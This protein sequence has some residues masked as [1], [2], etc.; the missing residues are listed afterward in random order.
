LTTP[1]VVN[2]ES[3]TISWKSRVGGG[4]SGADGYSVNIAD[5]LPD[6]PAYGS[7]GEEGGGSGLSLTVDQYD[8][9]GGETGVE[10]RWRGAQ[11]AFKMLPKDDDGTGN[12]LRKDTFVDASA[13]VDATGLATFTYDGNTI[14]AQLPNY[15]GVRANRVEI[16]GRTGGANDNHWIDDLSI[17]AFPFD[18]SAAEAGQTVTFQATADKPGMFSAGPAI[19]SDGT[20]TYTPAPNANGVANVTV[21]AKD[22]GGT[23]GGGHDT[24]APC[25]FTITLTPVNDCPT[26]DSQT[27]TVDLNS[28]ANLTLVGHDVDGDALQYSVSQAPAHGVVVLQVNT[29]A[30][31]YTPTAG[32]SGPDLFK[33]K[34]S[35]GHCDAEGTVTINV[36][37]ACTPPVAR[38]TAS[39]LVDFSPEVTHKVLISCNGS[40]ACLRL[41]GS[42][43]S[44]AESPLSELTF[45]WFVEPGALP[46]ATGMI[47][48]NCLDVGTQVI[49]LVVTDPCHLSG[50][51]SLTVDVISAG[52]AIDELIDRVNSSTVAR[53]NKRPFIAT[54][55]AASASAERGQTRTA[56][57]QLH[58]FQ[59]KVRA[60]V[61]KD[62]PGEAAI[63]TQWAQ[64]IIDAL[65][66][67]N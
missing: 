44:D 41:D 34:A 46:V 54:L 40:N 64:N 26:A 3:L 2:Y 20:L 21:V 17:V 66:R 35:D 57:N 9:G 53:K 4:D 25:S 45:Q 59:N 5:D 65:S 15:T 49:D 29:G 36:R 51:D 38:I 47:V 62:N 31:T 32:Y 28:T 63:W 42:L 1:G 55:K 13:S 43:S 37:T 58:A 23:A 56:A 61:S 8:N 19:A 33:F 22:N 60:Q 48:T 12:F 6:V 24:S 30:A 10:I 11:V 50:H 18:A 14:T 52:E 39:P 67:C 7:P 16:G 27:V